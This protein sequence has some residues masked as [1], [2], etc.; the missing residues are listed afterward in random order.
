M[1]EAWYPGLQEQVT[2]FI[3][4]EDNTMRTVQ[5]LLDRGRQAVGSHISE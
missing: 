2:A 4:V 1:V 3:T 5:I